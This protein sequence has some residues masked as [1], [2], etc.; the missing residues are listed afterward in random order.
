MSVPV[1]LPLPLPLSYP[2]QEVQ[3]QRMYPLPSPQY[4][5]H[6]QQHS[7]QLRK[8]DHL[9]TDSLTETMLASPRGGWSS[10]S[11]HPLS[12]TGSY[13]APVSPSNLQTSQPV[14]TYGRGGIYGAYSVST[15]VRN[16]LHPRPP[17]QSPY[18]QY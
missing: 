9:S 5:R 1:P 15:P 17:F 2:S 4:A 10:Q 13:S 14:P 11:I 16:V 6:T 18:G 12:P 8:E 3:S 7:Q